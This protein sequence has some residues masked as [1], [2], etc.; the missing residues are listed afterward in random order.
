MKGWVIVAEPP[1]GFWAALLRS[2][3]DGR[4][5]HVWVENEHIHAMFGTG[6]LSTH[7]V[8]AAFGPLRLW[9]PQTQAEEAQRLIEEFFA[10]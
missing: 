8:N 5:I 9:V 4:G 6:P 10:P 2:Y 7:P 1:N 3:L